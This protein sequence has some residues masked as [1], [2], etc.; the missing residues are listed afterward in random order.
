MAVSASHSIL[1]RL[2][3]SLFRVLFMNVI[4]FEPLLAAACYERVHQRPSAG[5]KDSGA[6]Q[7]G[8]RKEGPSIGVR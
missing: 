1:F 5:G 3:I 2:A 6:S 8:R 7:P 4:L